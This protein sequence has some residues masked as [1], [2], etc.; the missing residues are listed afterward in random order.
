MLSGG[1]RGKGHS[2]P[3]KS[4]GTG[5]P[6]GPNMFDQAAWNAL[7]NRYDLKTELIGSLENVDSD[8]L[9]ALFVS[10]TPCKN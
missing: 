3:S 10:Q 4:V 8:N 1:R 5:L 6:A 2:S 9:S 7:G